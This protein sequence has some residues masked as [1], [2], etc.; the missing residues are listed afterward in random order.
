MEVQGQKFL[1]GLL[2]ACKIEILGFRAFRFLFETKNQSG[3]L[4]RKFR[5]FHE[6]RAHK[7]KTS[8]STLLRMCDFCVSQIRKLHTFFVLRSDFKMLWKFVLSR[9]NVS[10]KAEHEVLSRNL[11][12]FTIFHNNICVQ[13]MKCRPKLCGR[14]MMTSALSNGKYFTR[15][16]SFTQQ[17]TPTANLRDVEATAGTSPHIR[18]TR[19]MKFFATASTEKIRR[20]IEME[21][22]TRNE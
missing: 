17:C 12:N 4:P 18:N 16:G 1:F 10:A 7:K 2:A 14:S 13:S 3:K 6:F 22:K 15:F 19:T 21:T 9:H 11:W 5:G 20:E 8:P